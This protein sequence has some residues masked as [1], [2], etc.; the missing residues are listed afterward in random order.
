MLMWLQQLSRG[1]TK[2]VHVAPAPTQSLPVRPV[3][4]PKKV[5]FNGP[6]RTSIQTANDVPQLKI[7]ALSFFHLFEHPA[8][9]AD[10]APFLKPVNILDLVSL[11][12]AVNLVTRFLKKMDAVILI[13]LCSALIPETL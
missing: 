7:S 1:G 5:A 11:P 8:K 9:A 6:N 4:V 13:F 12:I 2:S 3:T 10:V